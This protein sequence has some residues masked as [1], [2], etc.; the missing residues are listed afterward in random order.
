MSYIFGEIGIGIDL[1][2]LAL[3]LRDILALVRLF[4]IDLLVTIRSCPHTAVQYI[5]NGHGVLVYRWDGEDLEKTWKKV[6][7]V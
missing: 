1:F 6:T 2:L 3:L 4:R 7:A 5:G